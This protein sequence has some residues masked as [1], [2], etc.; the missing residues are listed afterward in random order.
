MWLPDG[1]I[2]GIFDAMEIIRAKCI[3]RPRSAEGAI[4]ILVKEPPRTLEHLVER[5]Y[6][7]MGYKTI[8]TPRQKDG[9]YEK[10]TSSAK[11]GKVKSGFLF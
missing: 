1:R 2:N 6:F 11:D 8:L 4:S 9:G 3:E 10:F 5:L 7:A